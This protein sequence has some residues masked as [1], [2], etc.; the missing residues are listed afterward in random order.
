MGDTANNGDCKYDY[1][2]IVDL[3]DM[4]YGG[5]G[6]VN[7][8]GTSF[9]SKGG[10]A[11]VIQQ[12]SIALNEA[13][14]DVD[15]YCLE[16]DM[17][18]PDGIGLTTLNIAQD[19]IWGRMVRLLFPLTLTALTTYYRMREYDIIV[20]HRYPFT[21]VGYISSILWGSKYVY[22]YHSSGTA[23]GSTGLSK[24]WLNIIQYLESR[25]FFVRNAD[26]ICAVS[27]SA[28]KHLANQIDSEIHVVNNQVLENRFSDVTSPDDIY[29][30]YNIGEGDKVVLYVGRIT[31]KKNVDTLIKIYS[32][33][34]NEFSGLDAKLVIAGPDSEPEYARRLKEQTGDD[35]IFTGY[36]QN[37]ADLAGLY[38][39][40][41]VYASCSERESW[42]LPIIE[43]QYFDIP[44]IAYDTHGAAL[45]TES[46]HIIAKGDHDSFRSAL[47]EEL[48]N[49]D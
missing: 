16:S 22:W 42:G 40:S 12:Q 30:K 7:L 26:L 21:A 28:K 43:A 47:R 45:E 23:E 18:A 17:A 29:S 3:F 37:D 49:D 24:I 41:T 27:K 44:V 5:G 46:K 25:N 2:S 19:S 9:T 39:I 34:G 14:Y 48:L 10:A 36:I 31:S 33:L 1:S 38:S 15:I 32:E 13:G 6:N 35:V 20:C 11:R 4:Y 8:C